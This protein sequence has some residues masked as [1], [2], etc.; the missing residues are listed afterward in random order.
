MNH[1]IVS[2]A[3]FLAFVL[4]MNL[5]S[6]AQSR[7]NFR[8]FD[9]QGLQVIDMVT[10]KDGVAWFGTIAGLVNL[11]QLNSYSHNVY[12]HS[13]E[14][15]NSSI[16]HIYSLGDAL[17]L[18]KSDNNAFLYYPRENRVEKDA[19]TLLRKQGLSL[20][21]N[22][23]TV[24]G[25]DGTHWLMQG[26][27][28]YLIQD[29]FSLIKT[30]KTGYKN[31]N[32]YVGATNGRY[33]AALSQ[34]ALYMVS[35]K[36]DAITRRT[37][38][39]AEFADRDLV[40]VAVDS[41]DDVWVRFH[42]RAAR[43]SL[44]ENRWYPTQT[45]P[46]IISDLA[47]DNNGN[48]WMA[49]IDDGIFIYEPGGRVTHLVYEPEN[50]QSLLNNRIDLLHFDPAT[51]T[52]WVA[53][54]KGGL[55]VCGGD[56]GSVVTQELADIT[57]TH[58]K[59]DI[60]TFAQSSDG[61]TIW[62]GCEDLGVFRRRQ[63]DSGWT[64]ILKDASATAL[65]VD[66]RGA[67]WAGLYQHG[68]VRID[69]AGLQTG[70]LDGMSVYAVAEDD[71]GNIYAGTQGN[72]LWQFR[73]DNGRWTDTGLVPQWIFDVKCQHGVVYAVTTEGLYSSSAEGKWTL[74][75]PGVFRYMQ[76]DSIGYKWLIGG[77]GHNSITLLDPD[78]KPVALPSEMAEHIVSN[79]AVDSRNNIWMVCDHELVM[80]R[81]NASD[82]HKIE[83]V[84]FNLLNGNSD[85]FYNYRGMMFA[86]NGD[87]WIGTSKGY[88]VIDAEY[89]DSITRAGKMPRP[90]IGSIT[91]NDIPVSAGKNFSGRLLLDSDIIYTK[92]IE[93]RHNENNLIIKFS[94][95]SEPYP[96]M[97][98]YQV[99]GLSDSW[100][101]A[102][103]NTIVLSNLSPGNYKV[104]VR[105]QLSEPELLL[106]IHIAQPLWLS[107]WAILIYAAALISVIILISNYFT[108]KRAYK[109]RI[110]QIEL[111]QEKEAQVNE[112]KLRFFTNISHD[113]RTPLSLILS[114]IEEL[115]GKA[116][117]PEQKGLLNVVRKN[118]DNLQT[119]VNQILDFRRLEFGR[120]KLVLSYGDIVQHLS[121]ICNTF[122]LK[123]AKE[124]IRLS[125]SSIAEHVDTIYDKDKLSKI[126][127]NLLSNAFKYTPAGGEISIG[128]NISDDKFVVTVSDTGC[129]IPDDEKPHIFERFYMA[130]DTGRPGM[131]SGIGL[132]IVRE[133]I[134]LHGGAIT[135]SDN[136]GGQGTQ[137]A[138][139]LPM[140]KQALTAVENHNNEPTPDET[141]EACDE[142]E[143]RGKTILLVDDNKDMLEYMRTSLSK[144]YNIITAA[145]GAIALELLKDNDVDLIIS[146]V[147]MPEVD[148]FTLCRRVKTDITTSHIPVVLLTAKTMSADELAGL[149]AGADDYITK[150]F[151]L[152]ILRQ[153]IC[154]LLERSA[155]QHERFV[156]EADIAPSEITV[157]SLD[158]RFLE[159]AIAIVENHIAEADFSVET[160]SAEMGMH[161]AQLYKK[162]Q[163]I[164]GKSPLEFI[165]LLRLKRG[166]QLLEQ[167]GLYVSEVA[168][169][170]GFNSPRIFSKYF[171]EEFGITPN[172]LKGQNT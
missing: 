17:L 162:L 2:K 90:V 110:H 167:S 127:M 61:Q 73:P 129:G 138:F 47:F 125:F 159:R 131:G 89:L 67:L 155:S 9:T 139:T 75:V 80:A 86:R 11:P 35:L 95:L 44:T 40:Y 111:Q 128:L 124:N 115:Q 13:E 85:I 55:S 106:E 109:L 164:T 114:P 30:L 172:S 148:G 140:R 36:D 137:F 65:T 15:L 126:M 161:R 93:L 76:T 91:V 34:Q 112:M 70:F 94:T 88:I 20:E 163:H 62:I 56:A 150:P 96:L 24:R 1:N 149:E 31:E 22:F 154:N 21:R 19:L 133:Y 135:V 57:G 147:I 130:S 66:S 72:G 105:S 48:R 43:Y 165:R 145:N 107:W 119:L 78:D 101:A 100:H 32:L 12:N 136:P 14:L 132:H 18:K 146:D 63:D 160:F 166:R 16:R 74:T 10:D 64:N 58:I 28:L 153:R 118:A 158:E 144:Y 49:T 156:S 103:D 97:M 84:S 27:G 7:Y 79:I 170:V 169:K 53:Y 29:D 46:S 59:A 38:L 134:Q 33:L 83:T 168:Y 42:N 4:L 104:Y 108:H 98:F 69:D 157:T 122:R 5:T 92:R 60:L 51:Q 3:L 99:D 37:E 143:E 52:M 39:P 82:P 121:D 171:K 26:D 45:Y 81:H 68:L 54:S 117:D 123:A 142:Q 50:Q 25:A 151:S 6:A 113:L 116:T 120:E 141:S 87:L 41:N 102:K 71:K 23:A 152:N 77:D 8:H